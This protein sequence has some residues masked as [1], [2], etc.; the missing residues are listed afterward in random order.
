MSS[1]DNMAGN[2]RTLFAI[3]GRSPNDPTALVAN[4]DRAH[5]RE[6]SIAFSSQI[7]LNAPAAPAQEQE[8]QRVA[9]C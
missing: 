3:Q 8:Q 7:A 4:I 2:E 9:M 1:I 6:Q 5:A